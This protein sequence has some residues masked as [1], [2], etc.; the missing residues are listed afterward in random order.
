MKL[1][2][3][4]TGYVGLV[5]GAC[6]SDMGNDV[7][8]VD[9]DEKK[10]KRLQE[11]KIPIYEPGLDEIVQRNVEAKRLKFTTRIEEA[12]EV[13]DI[14]FIAVGT[15]MGEDGSADLH[16]VLGVAMDIGRFMNHHMY[17]ID[18]STVP[19]GTAK[20]VRET[21]QSELDARGSSLEFDV[22]S[23]PEFL[24]EGTAVHDC[25][26]PDRIVIGTDTKRAEKKMRELYSPFVRTTE[27]L[28]LM[29]IASA[30]MTKYT[31]NSMLAT[32]ISF[33]NEISNI[34]ELV[35][36]DVNKVR[37]GIG[38][39]HRIGYQFIY[40]GCGYGGS[41]F[42]KDVQALIKTSVNNGYMPQILQ[43]VEDV[44]QAQKAIIP[45]KVVKRFGEDLNGLTFAAWGLAFKPDTDDMRQSAA[46]VIIEELTRRGAKINA[47]DPKAINEAKH[48]YLKG[49]K[50][51]TYFDGKYD[52]L[53]GCDAMIL[54]TEWKEFRSP[55]FALMKELLKT[56]VVFDGR[57]QYDSEEMKENGFEYYQIG[58]GQNNVEWPR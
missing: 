1:A 56:P 32:K 27:A 30:E 13:S 31:A 8:C 10:V 16:Y 28:I 38:S 45:A 20:K 2:I 40:P 47:Y 54:I 46:I 49:N 9:V 58:V 42:P 21:I 24:K 12:L 5:S 26:V 3:V 6:F 53:T 18:K 23:N 57:N 44:N 48:C 7:I 50:K 55:N 14:C 37:I 51:V 41:C 17:V 11:G 29:D 35:G 19:V 36:A 4:G 39:D 22:I 25:M 15:P 33:M 52:S 34:C 43:A